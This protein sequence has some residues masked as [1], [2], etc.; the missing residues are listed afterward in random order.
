MS[1]AAPKNAVC[2][3]CVSHYSTCIVF[4]ITLLKKFRQKINVP[5]LEVQVFLRAPRQD[6][7]VQMGSAIGDEQLDINARVVRHFCQ[8]MP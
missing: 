8:G 6:R 5:E 4:R 1:R 3:C 2:G 7:A